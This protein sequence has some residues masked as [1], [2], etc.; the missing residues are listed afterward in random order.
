[1]SK[2]DNVEFESSYPGLLNNKFLYQLNNTNLKIRP[3][4]KK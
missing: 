3:S 2:I 1:M 4:D